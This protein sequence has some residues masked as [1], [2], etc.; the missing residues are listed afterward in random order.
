MRAHPEITHGNQA[1]AFEPVVRHSRLGGQR[2]GEVPEA[3]GAQRRQDCLAFTRPQSQQVA[4]LGAH[5]A[6][7]F[8]VA[9]ANAPAQP[10]VQ[11]ANRA[12]EVGN[13]EVTHPPTDILGELVESVVHRDAPTASGQFPDVV[14]EVL[15]GALGP[16]QLL[17]PEGE[18][19][20]GARVAPHD[21]TLLRVDHQLELAGQE[22]RD[23]CHDPLTRSLAFDQDQQIVRVAHELVPPLLQLLV[24]IIQQDVTQDRR[25][26][27]PLRDAQSGR[28]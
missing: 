14:A 26:G 24:E 18:T 28:L 8:P 25:D 5:L 13:A 20:E 1:L 9:H 22:A 17:S 6:P 16:T 21:V 19:E 4:H 10:A 3:L 11:L 23:A 12:I 27:A 15:E 2:P 7:L